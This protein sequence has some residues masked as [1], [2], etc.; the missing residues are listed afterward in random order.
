MQT[1]LGRVAGILLV[2]MGA[3]SILAA[4]G[5]MGSAGIHS[6]PGQ[7][8]LGAAGLICG[9]LLLAAAFDL[10]GASPKAVVAIQTD[11]DDAGHRFGAPG[12]PS[13]QEQSETDW[14][15]AAPKL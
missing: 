5:G 3:A 8:V 15:A 7:W 13:S 14:F 11:P 6:W 2:L 4:L 10:H 12:Q 1:K 9:R